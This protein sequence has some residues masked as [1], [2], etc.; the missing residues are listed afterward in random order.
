VNAKSFRADGNLEARDSQH[1]VLCAEILHAIAPD[2]EL[3]FANWES[4]QPES[5]LEAVR[6]ARSQGA[7]VISC[8]LIMP[9]WSDGE[10]GGPVHAALSQIVGAGEAPRDLLCFAS[11]GNTAQRHWHGAFH[12]DADGWHRWGAEPADGITAG[13]DVGAK[14]NRIT[15]WGNERVSVEMYG[16]LAGDYELQVLEAKTGTVVGQSVVRR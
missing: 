4:D 5:F 16:A 11:A 6:W 14:T 2:A 13:N 1:G 7:R 12:A 3:L 9:S 10:G 15:P 8:S